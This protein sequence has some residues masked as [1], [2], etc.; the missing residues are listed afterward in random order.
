MMIVMIM[1][2]IVELVVVVPGEVVGE[3]AGRDDDNGDNVEDSGA[4]CGGT[5]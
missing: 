5:W 1:W 2:R 3:N 4:G